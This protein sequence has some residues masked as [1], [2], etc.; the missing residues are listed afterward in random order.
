MTQVIEHL[1]R[2]LKALSLNS[3]A[4]PPRKEK[5]KKKTKL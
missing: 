1:P 3:S 2:K 4:V 5:K